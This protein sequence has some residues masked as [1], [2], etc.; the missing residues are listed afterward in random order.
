MGT[1]RVHRV[2]DAT[3]IKIP[4]LSLDASDPGFFYPGQ[5]NVPTAV[6]ETRKLW[7]GS[8]DPHTG[9]LRQS[10]HV[11]L[12]R[13]PTHVILVDTG[14][15]N[16]KDRP[17]VPSLNHL[18]VPVLDRLKTA[19]VRPEEVDL[20][21]LT[22]L[23]VDH[24]LPWPGS[25]SLERFRSRCSGVAAV[26]EVVGALL[27]REGVGAQAQEALQPGHRPL[28]RLA[29][30]PLQLG[31]GVAPDILPGPLWAADLFRSQFLVSAAARAQG[32]T[33]VSPRGGQV[34]CG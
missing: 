2:G 16:D 26:G 30:Q 4:E 12:V 17:N 23:H 25:C 8:V 18:K 5:V 14:A 32:V 28:P 19:G 6:Q 20:V 11:W 10:I 33:G 27:G 34:A 13:T 22:H 29:Q 21:L 9:L 31:E 3:V 1:T 7:P 24:V 15:G